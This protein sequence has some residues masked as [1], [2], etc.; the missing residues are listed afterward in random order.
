MATITPTFILFAKDLKEYFDKRRVTLNDRIR[1]LDEY[2][3]E[4]NISDHAK[5]FAAGRMYSMKLELAHI[6]DLLDA[7]PSLYLGITDRGKGK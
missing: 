1:L 6:R 5:A 3:D 4:K 2:T 7:H